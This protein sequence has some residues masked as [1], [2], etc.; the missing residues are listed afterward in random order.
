MKLD[1]PI[2]HQRTAIALFSGGLDSLIA[3]KWMQRLGY[4]IYPVYFQTPYM[5][6]DRAILSATSNDIKLIIRDISAEHLAMMRNPAFGFGKNLNPCV[7]CHALMFK[8]AG[9]MLYELGAGFMISGEVLGQ[10]PMSQRRD[11]L[12]LVGKLS[13]CKDLI[14]RPLSQKL[15]SDTLPIREN[16]VT[17][18]DLLDFNG[19]SRNR[20]IELARE[21]GVVEYPHP[22]GGCLLT[23]R[24]YT[25]RLRDLIDHEQLDSSNLELL[26]YGRHFRIGKH[27]KLIVGRD[28]Q[29][30]IELEKLGANM[31]QILAKDHMGPLG[32]ITGDPGENLELVTSI[33][34]Y[35]VTKAPDIASVR[36][37]S[38]QQEILSVNVYKAPQELVKSHR[39]SYD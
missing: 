9:V 11:A 29:E 23:D 27:L 7:D 5:P 39:L 12:N 6:S 22:A 1:I 32:I 36:I 25:L 17:K 16:W 26:K 33:F 14:V 3:V 18:G 34:L 20:Q 21:L 28:E 24:N 35:Y 31:Y 38:P 2:S 10:R 4:T 15:L 19:R 13:E 30:N 37:K 8:V